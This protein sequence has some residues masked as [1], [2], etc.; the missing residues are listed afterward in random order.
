MTLTKAAY[1]NG[2]FKVYNQQNTP[3]RWHANNSRRIGPI[4]VVAD[5]GYAFHDLIDMAKIFEN[6]FNVSGKTTYFTFAFI[7]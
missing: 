1:Q 2:H 3:D 4:I 7:C 6:S 5:V